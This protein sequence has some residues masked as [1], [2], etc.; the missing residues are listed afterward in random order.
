[1]S[2]LLK[3][4][5]PGATI[6]ALTLTTSVAAEPRRPVHSMVLRSLAPEEAAQILQDLGSGEKQAAGAA[7]YAVSTGYKGFAK[8]DNPTELQCWEYYVDYFTGSKGWAAFILANLGTS[9]ATV[10]LTIQLSGPK[11]AKFTARPTIKKNTIVLY[12]G[13]TTLGSTTGL[14]TLT[15]KVT[16]AGVLLGGNATSRFLVTKVY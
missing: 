15:G 3:G 7:I 1:M 6:L 14:Y 10:N 5:L 8:P 9:D 4:V 11:S 13:E 16:G 2:R 12:Y